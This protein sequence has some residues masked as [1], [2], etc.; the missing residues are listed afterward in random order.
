MEDVDRVS[1]GFRYWNVPLKRD[2]TQKSCTMLLRRKIK[3]TEKR[4]AASSIKQKQARRTNIKLKERQIKLTMVG[5]TTKVS[6]ASQARS[7]RPA[8]IATSEIATTTSTTE[9]F[10]I[11]DNRNNSSRKFQST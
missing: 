2:S 7:G 1:S 5:A 4:A 8:P 10:K 6:S 3:N 9:T 11:R